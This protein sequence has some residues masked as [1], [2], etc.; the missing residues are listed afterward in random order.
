MRGTLSPPGPGPP[1]LLASGASAMPS[2]TPAAVTTSAIDRAARGPSPSSP[3]FSSANRPSRSGKR[4]EA[5]ATCPPRHSRSPGRRGRTG[6]RDD[7]HVVS[8]AARTR[9]WNH[10]FWRPALYQLS[11]CPLARIVS[12]GS[13]G[14]RAVRQSVRAYVE[15]MFVCGL[16]ANVDEVNKWIAR[17]A[18]DYAIAGITGIPRGTVQ[19]WRTKPRHGARSS[20]SMAAA[21]RRVLRVPARPL[22]RRRVFIAGA[23]R[24]ADRLGRPVSGTS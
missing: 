7:A 6:G 13:D 14:L 24:S 21:G 11:Y 22:S 10:R 20:G 17:G 23:A 1:R 4:A 8:G 5:T 18:S 9:T 19:R 2:R 12:A 16:C 15:H 3:S